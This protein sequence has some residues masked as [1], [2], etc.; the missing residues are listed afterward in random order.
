MSDDSLPPELRPR[1]SGCWVFAAIIIALLTAL[2]VGLYLYDL[3]MRRKFE[4]AVAALRAE[5]ETLLG[6]LLDMLHGE[7]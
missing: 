3:S 5:G 6:Q 4:A 7:R 2:G 1:S